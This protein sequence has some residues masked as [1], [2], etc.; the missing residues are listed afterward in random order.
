MYLITPPRFHHFASIHDGQTGAQIARCRQM[1]D[2][3]RHASCKAPGFEE[4]GF[5]HEWR[6]RGA[7]T[8]SSRMMNFG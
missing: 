4:I 6:H 7:E 2:H 1:G 3:D 8:G 5:G